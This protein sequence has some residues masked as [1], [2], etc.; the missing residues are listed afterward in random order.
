MGY[1]TDGLT[2]NTLM[3]ASQARQ[4]GDY[5]HLNWIP[6][7]WLQAV[8]GG[9]GE[10][11]NYRKKFERGDI[12]MIEFQ[13]NA[14]KELADTVTYISILAKELNLDLGRAIIEKFNE[15]SKRI[16]SRVYIKDDGSDYGL[17][18]K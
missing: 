17:R 12:D 3:K 16:D 18:V 6:A 9:L 7:Q 15:V 8:V 2:F 4:A 5:R 14:A 13:I 10:Y 1:M 11:A